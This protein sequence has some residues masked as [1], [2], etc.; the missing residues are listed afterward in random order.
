[1]CGL[2]REFLSRM[3]LA[4]LLLGSYCNN[5]YEKCTINITAM[6]EVNILFRAG[7]EFTVRH[8]VFFV[9]IYLGRFLNLLRGNN[10]DFSAE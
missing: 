5:F 3:Q 7:A 2:G 8:E 1:M 4:L 9:T 10:C 6:L